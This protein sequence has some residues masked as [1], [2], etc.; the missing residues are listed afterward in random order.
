MLD[1]AIQHAHQ[2]GYSFETFATTSSHFLTQIP[3]KHSELTDQALLYKIRHFL[4]LL[5]TAFLTELINFK[6]L[7]NV[8]IKTEF[9]AT[10]VAI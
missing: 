5:I 8:I 7:H 6:S 1:W 4:V 9:R 10:R 2:N 3:I